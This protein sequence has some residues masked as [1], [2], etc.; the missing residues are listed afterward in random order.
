MAQSLFENYETPPTNE[1]LS[2]S[3]L[4]EIAPQ[5]LHTRTHTHSKWLTTVYQPLF[6]YLRES[7]GVIKVYKS[8]S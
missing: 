4:E 6:L 5:P 7:E 8:F 1:G 2:V 3:H